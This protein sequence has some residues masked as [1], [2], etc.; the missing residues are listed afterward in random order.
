MA[1]TPYYSSF[2]FC[3]FWLKLCAKSE[4]ENR[5]DRDEKRREY[6]QNV[7]DAKDKGKKAR[8]NARMILELYDSKIQ[9]NEEMEKDLELVG[10]DSFMLLGAGLMAY[11]KML[12]SLTLCFII[13]G[14]L[15]Y[16]VLDAYK[17]GNGLK[18]FENVTTMQEYT[19]ANLGYSSL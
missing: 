11:R 6:L 1:K 13:M 16:P 9:A 3:C 2:P 15:M 18:H 5:E 7:E 12:F 19:I 17:S 14:A 4:E 10:G 8:K